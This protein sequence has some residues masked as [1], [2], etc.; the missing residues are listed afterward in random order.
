MRYYFF[1]HVIR[2]RF[3]LSIIECY[4]IENIDCFI[5]TK[6]ALAWYLFPVLL[7]VCFAAFKSIN[8][9]TSFVSLSFGT[10]DVV[11]IEIPNG[12]NYSVSRET[13]KQI[14]SF[15]P[16]MPIHLMPIDKWLAREYAYFLIGTIGRM[17]WESFI[18]IERSKRRYEIATETKALFFL[19]WSG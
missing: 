2:W 9:M 1:F 13:M 17:E 11:E 15:T 10:M 16:L 4:V 5:H 6:I 19:I 12:V 7:V 14:K 3:F 8:S 18:Q